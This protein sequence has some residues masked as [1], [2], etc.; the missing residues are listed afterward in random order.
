MVLVYVPTFADAGT[1]SHQS[2]ARFTAPIPVAASAV[3]SGTAAGAVGAAGTV[4]G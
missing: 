3:Y 4:S 2:L 1:V